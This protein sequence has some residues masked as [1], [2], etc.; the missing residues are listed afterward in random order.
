[1][2]TDSGS[3]VRGRPVAGAIL[4]FVFGIFL[5]ATLLQLGSFGLDSNLVVIVPV[6][7]LILGG[8]WGYL[9]PLRFLRR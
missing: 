1:M 9:A 2:T 4:G 3:Q 7:L 8:V 6:L 5:T